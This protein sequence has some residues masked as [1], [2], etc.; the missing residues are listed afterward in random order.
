MMDW[1]DSAERDAWERDQEPDP[2][3]VLSLDY[4][5]TLVHY[6]TLDRAIQ[7][8]DQSLHEGWSVAEVWHQ[9]PGTPL[10]E[11]DANQEREYAVTAAREEAK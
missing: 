2:G 5:D 11:V 3:Y 4:G 8:A 6:D 7:G 9:V 1:Q 10:V